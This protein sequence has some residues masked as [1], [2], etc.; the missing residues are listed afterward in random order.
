MGQGHGLDALSLALE[1]LH[2]SL[3]GTLL[4]GLQFAAGEI[5]LA[6]GTLHGEHLEEALLAT[7]VVVV[8]DDADYAVPDDIAD[9]HA[10]ALSHEGVAALLVDD[11]ALLVH[12]VVILREALTDT[13]VILLHLLLGA[14]DAAGDHGTLDT[15]ALLEAELVHHLGDTFRTE[16]TH[17][18]VLQRDV[19]DG[20]T[21]VALTAGTTTQL[22]V[23][24]ARLVAL[25]TDDGETASGL[26]L[27]AEFDIST[28]TSHVG[29]DGHG[30][31]GTLFGLDEVLGLLPRG[32]GRCPWPCPRRP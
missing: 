12:H 3:E 31:W 13:E 15:L 21:G 30:T 10:D 16:E 32:S 11:G 17:E 5:L 2:G 20:G 26:D 14:L 27:G 24:T 7:L 23:H 19:E 1:R 18:L 9:I 25:G 6:E 29:G 4:Q 28:T 8:G 22:A